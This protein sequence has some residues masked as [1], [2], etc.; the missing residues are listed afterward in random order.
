MESFLFFSPFN[1][2][3]FLSLDSAVKGVSFFSGA[4]AMKTENAVFAVAQIK[5]SK[6]PDQMQRIMRNMSVG[7]VGGSMFARGKL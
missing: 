5:L 6:A 4:L 2:L 7:H 1:K 3:P